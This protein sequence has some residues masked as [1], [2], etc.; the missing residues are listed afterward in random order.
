IYGTMA[1]A[2]SVADPSCD[3]SRV[4][5]RVTYF[6]V[7]AAVLV[8]LGIYQQR[9]RAELA[10]LAAWPRE[11]AARLDE[12]LR[13][14]LTHAAA[15]LAAERIVLLWEEREEAWLYQAEWSRGDFRIDRVA[16]TVDERPTELRGTSFF[17]RERSATT[18]VYDPRVSTVR[19]W[20]GQPI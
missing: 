8:Y 5:T 10:S 15:V 3:A 17:I 9:L 20:S 11:L 14:T 6:G 4:L 7:I 2:A 19:D 12:L 18:L 1:L 16:P 13:T